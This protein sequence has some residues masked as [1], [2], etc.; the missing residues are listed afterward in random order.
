M[1]ARH[2]GAEVFVDLSQMTAP[3]AIRRPAPLGAILDKEGAPPPAQLNF[4]VPT[5]IETSS[6]SGMGRPSGVRA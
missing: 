4:T 5:S 2:H 1:V 6:I 3:R